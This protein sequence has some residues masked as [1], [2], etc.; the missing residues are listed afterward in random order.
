MKIKTLL[1]STLVTIFLS[2]CG[3]KTTDHSTSSMEEPDTGN[4][5]LYNEIMNIHDEVMP[6]MESLYNISKQLKDSVQQAANSAEQDRLQMR[7]NYI[8]SVSKMMMDWMHEFKPLPD[9][10]DESIIQ[11]YYEGHLEKIKQV[12]EAILTALDKGNN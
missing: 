6:K 5:A 8:D 2:G 10:T 7:Q 12:R 3:T 11:E 4:N 9:T 1:I